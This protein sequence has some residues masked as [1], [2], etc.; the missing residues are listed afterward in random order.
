V[1]LLNVPYNASANATG[2]LVLGN[3]PIPGAAGSVHAANGSSEGLFDLGK[4]LIYGTSNYLALGPGAST[5]CSSQLTAVVA[6]VASG[7]PRAFQ[8]AGPGSAVT[9]GVESSLVLDEYRSVEWNMDY[10]TSVAPLANVSVCAPPYSALPV[11]SQLNVT[12][13]YQ[14]INFSVAVSSIQ[15]FGYSFPSDGNWLFQSS[16]SGTWAFAY[17]PT[18]C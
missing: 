5:R 8:L 7:V 17:H 6:P 14:N 16:P 15:V 9:Q 1:V 10:R 11:Y 13:P 12:V 4:W 3:E 2:V 18:I